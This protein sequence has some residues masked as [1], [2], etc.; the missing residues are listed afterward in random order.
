MTKPAVLM[1]LTRHPYA[2]KSG[3]G[4]MLRQRVE[5]VRRRFDARIVVFGPSAGDASD[6]GLVFLP[7]ANPAAIALNSA[8]LARLPMQTWLYASASARAR[9]AALAREANARAVYVD[10]LRLAPLAADLPRRIALIVD[11]DDLLSERYRVA[12]GKNYD[13]MG[14]MTKRMGPLAGVA[15]GFARPL[16][17]SESQRCAIYEQA[18]LS[19]CDLALFT[20][21]REAALMAREGAH[22]LAAP[23]LMAA[24]AE[25]AATGRRLIFLG[26]MLYAENITMLQ[27]L[28][29]AAASLAAE[30]AWPNDAI[31]DAVGDHA[32]DLP[33]R[34]DQCFIRFRG[35]ADDLAELAGQGVFLAPVTSGSGVKIKM[36][37]GLSL[38][39]PIVATPKACEGLNVRANRDLLT[40][41]NPKAVLRAALSLRD[42]AR[43]KAMLAKRGRAY[44]ARAHAPAIGDAVGEA[45]AAAIARAEARHETL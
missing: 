38:S 34:F 25:A 2:E 43:L 17:A 3:R 35:R 10:M 39:C 16:L 31:I 26:N 24:R 20:S 8:R 1:L 18:L 6:E 13:V 33:A 42:R 27:S 28:A 7:M 30:G 32:P 44:L 21:P 36:L 19:R 41:P 40:A 12:T 15:R 14:F 11:Y 5:Q 45:I 4:F 9:V 23:P 29:E 22:V 37:D